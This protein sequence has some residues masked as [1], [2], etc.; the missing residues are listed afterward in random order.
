MRLCAA[1]LGGAALWLSGAGCGKPFTYGTGGAGGGGGSGSAGGATTTSSSSSSGTTACTLDGK[2]PCAAKEYCA[3]TDCTKGTCAPIPPAKGQAWDPV[4]GCDGIV[5]W[6]A[7]LA[8]ADG[9]GFLESNAC[10]TSALRTCEPLNDPC[11]HG[12]HAYCSVRA[13]SGC[14]SMPNGTCVKLPESCDG[15][16]GTG[17]RCFNSN[18]CEASCVLIKS[19]KP[20]Y[21]SSPPCKL[22]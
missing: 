16:T 20:W 21:T 7:D 5:Y 14:G 15:T 1:T 11:D 18:G 22:P 17:E 8:L 6:N 12:N 9:V 4:C 3:T 2:Q 13:D 10:N 19:E